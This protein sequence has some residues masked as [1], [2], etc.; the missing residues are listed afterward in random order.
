MESHPVFLAVL[1]LVSLC[2]SVAIWI[3]ILRRPGRFLPK[4]ILL[5]ISA[6]PFFGPVFFIF[7]DAPPI[8]PLS[9]QARPFP[10]GTEIYSDFGTLI[11]NLKRFF[12]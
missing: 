4:F 7:F 8:L 6:I 1:I 3:K 12:S 11:A 2:A 10:K 9:E 5:F